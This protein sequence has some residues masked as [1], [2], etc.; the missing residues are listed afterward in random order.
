MIAGLIF[1]GW[2]T[3]AALVF[4]LL[5]YLMDGGGALLLFGY[6]TY[7]WDAVSFA[8]GAAL[9]LMAAIYKSLRKFQ[10]RGDHG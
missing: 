10:T 6:V 7:S 3:L 5:S 2:P 1:M 9:F 8:I 4:N